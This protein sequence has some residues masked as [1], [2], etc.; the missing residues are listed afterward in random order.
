MRVYVCLR[1]CMCV[2]VCRSIRKSSFPH[3]ISWYT[4][5]YAFSRPVSLSVSKS[6]L[7]V[8]VEG[9]DDATGWR[10][11]CFFLSAFLGSEATCRIDYGTDSSYTYLPYN[12][13]SGA[14]NS[15]SI[16]LQRL[17]SSTTY[18]YRVSA[19]ESGVPTITV[20]GSFMTGIFSE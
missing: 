19:I 2:G 6:P 3:A 16:P 18:Y 1:V 13:T 5:Y 8:S 9:G 20:Q 11:T 12:D 14:N 15:M 17:N 7:T 10:V 4:Q